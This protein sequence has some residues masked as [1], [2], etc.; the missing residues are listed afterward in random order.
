MLAADD[1]LDL[2]VGAQLMTAVILGQTRDEPQRR[3]RDKHA[4]E[5]FL[6][7]YAITD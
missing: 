1:F 6:K 5:I 4:V 3:N 2:A 7:N